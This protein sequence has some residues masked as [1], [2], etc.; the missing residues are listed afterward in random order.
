MV[1]VVK[2]EFKVRHLDIIVL[3]PMKYSL[4]A[5]NED[6]SDKNG[7]IFADVRQC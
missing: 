4:Y 5:C 1:S 7:D 3:K 6:K 2:R